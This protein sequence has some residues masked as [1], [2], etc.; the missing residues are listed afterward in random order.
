[1]I[2]L[3]LEVKLVLRG[4][5]LTQA[6]TAG[7]YGI[8]ATMAR[9]RLQRPY[10]PYS[11]MRG[12]LR[13]ALEEL[14]DALTDAAEGDSLRSSID[15]WFGPRRQEGD[16]FNNR[17]GA[18]FFSDF[19]HPIP[20]A[21]TQLLSRIKVDPDSGTVQERM[22]MVTDSPFQYGEP[23]EFNGELRWICPDVARI[24]RDVAIL[25]SG[26][27][28]LTQLGAERTIGYGRVDSVNI[29]QVHVMELTPQDEAGFLIAKE[30]VDKLT[31]HV[32]PNSRTHRHP[33]RIP[34]AV[35]GATALE[36][37]YAIRIRP[38]K[39]FCIAGMRRRANVF[40]SESIIP[41]S[42]ILGALAT[43]YCRAS[44]VPG[45]A[46]EVKPVAGKPW[47][48]LAE[49]FGKM[50]FTHAF[51][52]PR[53]SSER[54]SVL[55][56]SLVAAE[57]ESDD[58]PDVLYDVA[59]CPRPRMVP[60][61]DRQR[62]PVFASDWKRHAVAKKAKALFG[63]PEIRR[64]SRIRTAIEP[65]TLRA[66]PEQLFGYEMVDPEGFDWLA[67]LDLSRVDQPRRAH[68]LRDLQHLLSAGLGPLG[69]TKMDA[70]IW[71]A[72]ADSIRPVVQSNPVPLPGGYWVVTLQTP[73]LL[74]RPDDLRWSS[75]EPPDQ[76][77]LRGYQRVVDEL[78]DK[79]LRLERFFAK[80]SLSSVHFA[81]QL[82]RDGRGLYYPLVLTDEGSTFVLQ[83][84]GDEAK[85]NQ[86]IEQ[87]LASGIPVPP[88]VAKDIDRGFSA[89][90]TDAWKHCPILNTHGFGEVVVNPPWLR[91]TVP[92]PSWPITLRD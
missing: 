42:T 31:S 13:Q 38:R 17:R 75:S 11:L 52:A 30:E 18:L 82:P 37:R 77:L 63:W 51:P 22:L 85:A 40:E 19:V 68:V 88:S 47:Q 2:Q 44:G 54:P 26:L 62:P 84:A 48:A 16:E 25:Q 90:S 49:D 78:S 55:P 57:P 74:C 6:T 14:Q 70:D 65:E 23:V 83:A 61:G 73:A 45:G 29:E 10:L 21:G 34:V 46:N 33:C 76:K 59:L 20:K 69:K 72:P 24:A 8:D 80:Q 67:F 1:M 56:L 89:N 50:R 53:D 71:I 36:T 28:W 66:A 39:P 27:R 91:D 3:R 5:I 79:S 92:N 58:I 7:A 64:E 15:A 87:W 35:A 81:G 4:P 9:D 32:N 41:G 12:K 60:H 86:T 43:T